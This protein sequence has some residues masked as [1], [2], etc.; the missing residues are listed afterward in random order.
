V[1]TNKKSRLKENREEI[2]GGGE[3]FYRDKSRLKGISGVGLVLMSLR[4]K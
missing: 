1:K 4:E 2:M 3:G